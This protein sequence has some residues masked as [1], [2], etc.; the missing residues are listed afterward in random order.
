MAE[1]IFRH[2]VLRPKIICTILKRVVN[3]EGGRTYPLPSQGFDPL[4][5]QRSTFGTIWRNPFLADD[6]KI[7]L[8][9]H[10]LPVYTDFETEEREK[11]HVIS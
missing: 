11:K 10:S 2:T 7:F 6:L 5:T 3:L 8:K 9:E 1:I 4:F